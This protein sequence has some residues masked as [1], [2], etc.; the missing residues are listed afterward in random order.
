MD[1]LTL[2]EKKAPRLPKRIVLTHG[3][4][5]GLTSAMIIQKAEKLMD[6]DKNWIVISSLNPTSNE[7]ERMFDKVIK[8]T[9]LGVSDRIY[10]TDRAMLGSDYIASNRK[11]LERTEIIYIDH[12]IT[13]KPGLY[14]EN[15]T[16]DNIIN[17]WDDK[18]SG[19]TLTFK[20]FEQLQNFNMK[21]LEEY[22]KI[23]DFAE[24][25]R[26]WDI[27]EWTN[28]PAG[29]P[30]RE[31]A[32]KINAF[33]KI[34]GPKFLYKKLMEDGGI[35]KVNELMDMALEVYSEEYNRYARRGLN[36]A[37]DYKFD[38]NFIKVFFDFDRKYQ[39]L[40]AY[41]LLYRDEAD[42]VAF[43]NPQGTVSFRSKD[44]VDTSVIAKKL[45]EISGFTGGG[46]KTASNYKMM[47]QQDVENSMLE[48]FLE[49][50]KKLAEKENKEFEDY[51]F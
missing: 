17:F 32:L 31:N 1:I 51:T 49:D 27:F 34:F 2:F 12:H 44:D 45:A 26:L 33:E 29:A 48:R 25:V 18:E 9:P 30:E 20:W 10:I 3:D 22:D 7:T 39:S 19:A 15:I 21:D 4:A 16:L 47:E 37:H 35:D 36:R 6:K 14:K 5:D 40:F 8:L 24:T 13:N 28:Y 11:Y 41:E 42:I 46:H 38:G 43:I 23:K 50:I